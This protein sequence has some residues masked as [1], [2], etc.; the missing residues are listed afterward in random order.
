MSVF[1][2]VVNAIV[3]VGQEISD[4][5]TTGLYET[6]TQ[7]TA[8]FIKWSVVAMFKAKLAALE[9]SW[10]VAQELLTSLNISAYLNNA[11]SSLESRTLSMLVFFR[12]PEAVNIVLGA[13]V[14]K[15]VMRFIGFA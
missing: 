7:W 9:F 15:F 12:V 14:T 11:W 1:V 5:F 13:G 4:F 10:D 3:S 6:L 2:D 8:W